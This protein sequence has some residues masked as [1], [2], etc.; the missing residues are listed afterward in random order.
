MICFPVTP[1]GK[2]ISSAYV[3]IRQARFGLANLKSDAWRRNSQATSAPA[4]LE[5]SAAAAKEAELDA[6]QK[7]QQIT[8]AHSRASIKVINGCELEKDR[9]DWDNHIIVNR[10]N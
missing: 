8:S 7:S 3:G 1:E 2:L 9:V 4:V 6:S 10:T 5:P